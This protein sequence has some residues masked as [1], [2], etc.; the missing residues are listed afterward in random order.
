MPVLLLL[1][2]RLIEAASAA[3]PGWV[4]DDVSFEISRERIA[5]RGS[6]LRPKH[7]G[8]GLL[9]VVY[10]FGGFEEAA[11]VL[12]LIHPKRPIAVASFDYPFHAPRRFEF[13]K[14]F[15]QITEARRAIEL[16]LE[17]IPAFHAEIAKKYPWI[18]PARVVIAGAS[19]GA[20]FAVR[21]AAESDV[22]RGLV[23]VHGFGQIRSTVAHVIHKSWK[24]KMHPL[25]AAPMSWLAATAVS[26]VLPVPDIEAD[27]EK[28]RPGQRVLALEALDDQFVPEPARRS[29][30]RS[31]KRSQARVEWVGLPGDHLQPG[32]GALIDDLIQRV[33]SWI[34]RL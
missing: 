16:T 19:F 8:K 34:D 6:V 25:L 24:R 22:F 14:S 5:H 23:V 28:L 9:P 31:L 13:L 15:G 20:P 11:R 26:I 2:F 17:G 21:A 18:D 4:V 10:L 27:A 29:L 1:W 12:D 32:S 3:E 33:S 7:V 30:E